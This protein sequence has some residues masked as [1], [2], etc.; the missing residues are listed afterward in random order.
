MSIQL[1][2]SPNNACHVADFIT[3]IP[4]KA[5]KK[6]IR[7]FK[8]IQKYGVDSFKALDVRKFANHCIWEMKIRF[9]KIAYRFLFVI[10]KGVMW[11][12]HA[13]I[14]KGQKTPTREIKTAVKRAFDLDTRV[15]AVQTSKA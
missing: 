13:F 10:R 8:L 9:N 15:L 4:A 5:K 7:D 6:V 1:Y 12:L 2:S 11:L 3:S 14:K